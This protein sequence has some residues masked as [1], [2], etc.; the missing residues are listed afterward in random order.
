MA[1]TKAEGQLDLRWREEMQWGDL[2][3]PIRERARETLGELLR[4][5]VSRAAGA[6]E[7]DDDQ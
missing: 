6:E 3:A 1:K 5:A 4:E 2:P 7:V